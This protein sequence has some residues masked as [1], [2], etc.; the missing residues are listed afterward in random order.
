MTIYL[1]LSN[2][3]E[4]FTEKHKTATEQTHVY[5]EQISQNCIIQQDE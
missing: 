3:D 5:K 4:I 2:W 1:N